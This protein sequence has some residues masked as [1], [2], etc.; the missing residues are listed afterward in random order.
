M[1]AGFRGHGRTCNSPAM[2]M[3]EG[4]QSMWMNHRA[5]VDVIGIAFSW[6]SI[7]LTSPATGTSY[8]D[9]DECYIFCNGVGHP[10]D[11]VCCFLCR[12]YKSRTGD[13]SVCYFIRYIV[14]F[15]SME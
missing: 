14:L 1:Q 13:G 15:F 8:P 10:A 4:M 3:L 11:F 6:P 5:D 9:R 2:H 12:Y 7:T